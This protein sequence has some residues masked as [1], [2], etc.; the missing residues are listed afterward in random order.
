MQYAVLGY[1]SDRVKGLLEVD[2]SDNKVDLL[3]LAAL[4]QSSQCKHMLCRGPVWSE[5]ILVVSEV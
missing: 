4:N 1:P 5:A 3:G 2:E